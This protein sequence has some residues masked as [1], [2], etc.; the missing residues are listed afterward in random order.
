MLLVRTPSRC[1]LVEVRFEI[2]IADPMNTGTCLGLST[3]LVG[4]TFIE[5]VFNSISG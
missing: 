2:D 5:E 1:L 3:K 4:G